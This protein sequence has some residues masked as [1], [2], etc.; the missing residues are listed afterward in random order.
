MS[1]APHQVEPR[2]VLRIADLSKRFDDQLALDGVDLVLRAGEVCAL[3]GQ[4]GSGK[5]TLIKILAGYHQADPGASI[6]FRGRAV[7]IDD[8]AGE[9]RRHVR[10][11]HQDLGLVPT[12]NVL[13]NLALGPGYR[14]GRAHRI[15]WRAERRRASEV[16]ARFGL[17]DLD[18]R[19][20]VGSLGQVEKTLIAVARALLDWDDSQG[21]LVLDEPTAA[22]SRPEVRRL[23]DA[24]QPLA[25]RGV[26]ILFVSHRLEEAFEIA[27]RVVVLRDGRVVAARAI[28]GLDE[29]AL[30]ELMIGGIPEALY[31]AIAAPA[32]DQAFS[33]R[34]LSGARVR[35]LSLSLQ[36]GEIVGVA[37]LAG[38]GREDLPRL[39][40]GDLV[41]RRG[42]IIVEDRR[43]GRPSPRAAIKLGIVLVPSDRIQRSLFGQATVRENITL[44]DLHSVCRRGRI[45]RRRERREVGEWI[46]RV[47]LKPPST[48]YAM[49]HLS[50]GNQQ[51]GVIAR[52]LRM[53]P[54]V[55]LLDEPTQGVDVGAK[56][57]I[58]ALIADAAA[59]GAAV[60]MC[61][62]EAK[63][64]AAVCDRVLVLRHGT[65]VADLRGGSLREER[66]V[67]AMLTSAASGGADAEAQVEVAG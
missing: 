25:A 12:M 36:R 41:A 10:F 64:L 54:R 63:D 50:G 9:W 44:P 4:N 43:L 48:E 11:I 35:E 45:D 20:P 16:L 27:D 18:L 29:H 14:T 46:A 3:I 47:R 66:I 7:T 13:D 34:R 5:S 19:A 21:V 30:L 31:P 49:G 53:S 1:N 6:E 65:V 42:E 40:F 26:A 15:R 56:S 67:A 39:L 52:W 2:T 61:S 58:F 51:K 22:L 32:L 59:A 24:M 17:T 55:L 23:F 8:R 57:A 62:S 37:G 38:S 28:D 60:L 33:V